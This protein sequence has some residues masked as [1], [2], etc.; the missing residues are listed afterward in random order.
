MENGGAEGS[1]EN[2]CLDEGSKKSWAAVAL[3]N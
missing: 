3:Y 1:K 2:D